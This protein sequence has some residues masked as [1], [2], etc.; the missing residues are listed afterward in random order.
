VEKLP[1]VLG[2]RVQLRQLFVNLLGN[3][4]KFCGEGR[5]PAIRI[6]GQMLPERADGGSWARLRV[7][8]DGIGFSPE[9][10][11][12]IFGVFER[13]HGRDEFAGTGMGLAIVRRIV[14]QHGGSVRAMS[15][16]DCGAV[17][18]VDLPAAAKA[19]SP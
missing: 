4:L 18:E 10:A 12:K 16:P 13:L 17:F 2:D 3:A 9:Y 7:E 19:S 11:E 14:E 1:V 15:E 5:S 8:D 6:S